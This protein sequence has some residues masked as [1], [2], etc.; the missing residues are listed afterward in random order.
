MLVKQNT[1]KILCSLCFL[2]LLC[3]CKK[4]LTEEINLSK[5]FMGI[6]GTAVF[7]NPITQQYKIHNINLSNQRFSPCSTFK[8]MSSYIALNENIVSMENSQRQWNKTIYWHPLWNKDI[9]I[10]EAFKV[11]CVWYYRQLIDEIGKQK[12]QDYL[13]K[14]NYG[15]QDA[16]DWDGKLNTNT[17]NRDLTGFW[18]ESSLKISPQEQVQFLSKLFE[19]NTQVITDLKN[20]M[21]VAESPIKIYGKTGMGVKDNKIA[22]AWFVGFYEQKKQKIFFAVRLNDSEN[23]NVEDY[24]NK[25]SYYAKQIAID[26]I[27]NEN[28]F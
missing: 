26:I 22:N 15:N 4:D 25:A 6:N 5:Y 14:F 27:N 21:Q 3:T 19:Q 24:R 16:S 2:L 12:L 17:Q 20:I 23:E 18:I 8:I 10:T 13:T 7:Y 28:L 9:A 1:L 11:S